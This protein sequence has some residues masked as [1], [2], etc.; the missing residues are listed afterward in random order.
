MLWNL[1]FH[2]LHCVDDVR[3]DNKTFQSMNFILEKYANV[4]ICFNFQIYHNN[5]KIGSLSFHS[6]E[7]VL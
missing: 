1:A 3:M 6:F 4:G 7:Q 5:N 2:A